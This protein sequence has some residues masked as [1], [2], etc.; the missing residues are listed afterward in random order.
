MELKNLQQKMEELKGDLHPAW[1][2][3]EHALK[4]S[5]SPAFIMGAAAMLHEAAEADYDADCRLRKSLLDSLR[6]EKTS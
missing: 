4:V 5:N 6:K 1:L 2:L 3:F